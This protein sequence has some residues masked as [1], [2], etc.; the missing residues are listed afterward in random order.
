MMAALASKER[1]EEEWK[2]LIDSAGLNLENPLHI[3]K[4][5]SYEGVIKVSI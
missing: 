2:A 5:A 1:T 3:Y 4:P